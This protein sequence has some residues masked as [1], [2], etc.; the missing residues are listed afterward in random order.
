MP[1]KTDRAAVRRRVAFEQKSAQN[2]FYD[3]GLECRILNRKK[4]RDLSLIVTLLKTVWSSFRKDFLKEF[5]L[6]R[7]YA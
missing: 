6:K 3:A 2:A 7:Y 1:F 4:N 5:Y